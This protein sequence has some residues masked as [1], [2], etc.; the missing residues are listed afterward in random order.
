MRIVV[1]ASPQLDRDH[2]GI[3]QRPALGKRVISV[4]SARYPP[5]IS[6]L[7]PLGYLEITSGSDRTQLRITSGPHGLCCDKFGINS[8]LYRC[9]FG[10][11]SGVYLCK[12]GISSG[13]NR[14]HLGIGL[15]PREQLGISVEPPRYPIRTCVGGLH[16]HYHGP[17]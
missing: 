15:V 5:C 13:S 11:S 1:G 7:S 17:C 10:I 9:T 12:F 3:M 8:G 2:L 6:A 4:G 16:V 14:V